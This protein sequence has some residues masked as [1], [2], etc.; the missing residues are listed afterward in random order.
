MIT[1]RC[2]FKHPNNDCCDLV[3]G[4]CSYL[5]KAGWRPV[6]VQVVAEDRQK[7]NRGVRLFSRGG[8]LC[9]ECF[10]RYTPR[11]KKKT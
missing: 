9:P 7:R 3:D 4:Y 1:F 5:M 11:K 2:E 10:E 8:W 6:M